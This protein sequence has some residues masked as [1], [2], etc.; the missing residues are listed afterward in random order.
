MDQLVNLL[1]KDQVRLDA[2]HYVYQLNLPDCY[3]AAGFVRNLVWDSLHGLDIFTPLNDVDVIYFEPSELNASV[4][5]EYETRLKTVMPSLNWQ[6][7]N[8][9]NMH[10]RNGDRRY[11]SSLDAMS[12]WP[13][14]ETA[15]GIRQIG[16][17]SYECIAAFGFESLFSNCITHNPKRSKE[18]FE[19]RVYGKN[20]LKRWPDLK[21]IC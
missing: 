5:L 18:V 2:L 8:Q 14:K 3:V 16:N 17:D 6:V 13:E 1:K 7:R 20:W 4:Y 21:V 19:T 15:V 11:K 10:R 9:A 12:Y